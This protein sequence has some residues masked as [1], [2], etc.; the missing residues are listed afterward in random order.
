MKK[1]DFVGQLAERVQMSKKEVTNLID[2]FSAL[3][4]KTLKHGD[5]ACLD[6]G[7]FEL[8]KRAARTGVN[9]ATGEKIKVAAKVVPAFKPSKR[10][11]EA[12]SS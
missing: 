1:S 10:F 5:V 3:I 6:I 9:P 7:K 8:K 11:K 4:M 2:E 12:V